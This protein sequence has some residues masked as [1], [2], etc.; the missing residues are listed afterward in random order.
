MLGKAV[1]AEPRIY[2]EDVSSTP[3]IPLQTAAPAAPPPHF[4]ADL[5]IFDLAALDIRLP[6]ISASAVALCLFVGVAVGHPG[7]ALIAGGGALTV[8][9]GANQRIGDSRLLPMLFAVFAMASATLAGTLAGHRGF[10][11]ILFSAV[12]AAIYGILTMRHAGI[13]WVG[14]QAAVALFVASAF[15]SGPRLSFTRAGLIALGGIVQI[16]FTSVGLRII[17][18]LRHDLLSIPRS[19]YQQRTELLHR[20]RQIPNALPA[21]GHRAAIVYAIRLVLTV[22]LASELYRRLGMQSGYWV[23]MTALLVQKPAFFETLSRGLARI[24][25]TLAGATLATLLAAHVQLNPWALAALTTFF[26]FWSFATLSVNYALFTLCLTSYIVFLLSLN[27]IPGPEI[28][29]RRAWCTV[30]GAAIAFLIHLDALRR[31]RT[32]S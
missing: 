28:A 10:L 14:Q 17:P 29:H 1:D 22:T 13:A 4:L 25:G 30:A 3:A 7:G 21:P 9:F 6:L 27:Q 26:A 32:A 16:I 23:P 18:E 8:G 24:A 5:Y 11:L 12:A 20:L 31:H 19:L 2:P 15:P